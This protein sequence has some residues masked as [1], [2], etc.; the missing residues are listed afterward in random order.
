MVSRKSIVGMWVAMLGLLA[1]GGPVLSQTTEGAKGASMPTVLITGSNRGIGL[2]LARQYAAKGWRVIAT[3]RK[4]DAATELKALAAASPAVTIEALDVSDFAA[5]DALAAKYAGTPIDVL[6]NN[7]GITGGPLPQFFGRMQWP[8][9]EEVL[10]VNTIAPLK[11]AEAFI[12][13]VEA[14][15]Q[16]KIVSVS[17]SEGSISAVSSARMYFYRASK[18]ALNMEMRNL[19]FQLKKRGVAVG[20]I[21]PGPVAT[22]MMK[23]VP[24]KLREIPDA[25]ADIIR[26][27]DGLNIENTGSFWNYDGVVLGW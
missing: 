25:A 11:M 17:S 16:K 22:D 3:C 27:T 4:P 14:S 23:G 7:A 12:R 8:V 15:G 19:S 24:M 9:F 21:N 26:I 5:I 13:H 18:A 10:R 2:E 6:M 20:M 1:S